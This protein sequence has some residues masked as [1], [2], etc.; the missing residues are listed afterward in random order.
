MKIRTATKQETE[1]VRKLKPTHGKAKGP[2]R[3]RI[4]AI[5][6]EIA[7]FEG[8]CDGTLGLGCV[9]LGQVKSAITNVQFKSPGKKF[10][11]THRRGNGAVYVWKVEG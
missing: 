3:L 4:E 9:T 10:R 1:T 5:E 8:C 6:D 11:H 7:V 2:V